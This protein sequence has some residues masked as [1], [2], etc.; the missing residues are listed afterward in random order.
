MMARD[1][2]VAQGITING[3]PLMTRDDQFGRWNIDALDQ[4]Y[5]D[6]VIGGSGAFVV[7]V[8]DWSE[9]AAA[10]RKK[11]VLEIAGHMPE[12]TPHRIEHDTGAR[13]VPAQGYDCLIG[14]KIWEQYRNSWEP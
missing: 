11:L 12:Q 10:V 1:A 7:P 6:C 5:R 8:L 3:L 9:F 2:V 13:V 4:Y 14:E